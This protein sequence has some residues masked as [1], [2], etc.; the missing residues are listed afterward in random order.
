M[1]LN[2]PNIQDPLFKDAIHGDDSRVIA[3]AVSMIVISS[4]LVFLR[5][6]ARSVQRGALGLDDWIIV[7]SQ[8][9]VLLLLTTSIICEKNLHSPSAENRNRIL[10]GYAVARKGIGQHVPL[11][12]KTITDIENIRKCKPISANWKITADGRC[13]GVRPHFIGMT[14]TNIIFDILTLCLPIR[15]VKGLQMPLW[16][17]IAVCGIFIAG[18]F[19]TLV[20][21]LIPALIWTD[22]EVGFAIMCACLPVLRP[23]I[24]LVARPFA[25]IRIKNK[26]KVTPATESIQDLMPDRQETPTKPPS[27]VL[28][29]DK[30]DHN[31]TV[32]TGDGTSS[33]EIALNTISVKKDFRWEE[34]HQARL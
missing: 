27:L 20:N 15:E 11:S 23:I 33:T 24:R 16:K 25:A 34:E 10:S 19:V 31:T 9:V 5:F 28:R 7:V 1:A 13:L 8:A 30:T 32:Y 3:V 29:K 14:V 4:I 21:F 18:G 17:K 22:I 2:L 6:M 12:L 26:T